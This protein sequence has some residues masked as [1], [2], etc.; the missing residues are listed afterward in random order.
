MSMSVL[1]G[2]VIKAAKITTEVTVA[3]VIKDIV[4]YLTISVRMLTNVLR[5]ARY[6]AI[7]SVRTYLAAF[8][9]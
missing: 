3:S 4:T 2:F 8:S 7:F 6:V 5:T 1:P 9:V